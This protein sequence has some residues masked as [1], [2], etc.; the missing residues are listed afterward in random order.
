MK[1]LLLLFIVTFFGNVIVAQYR[2]Y[3][4]PRNEI[5]QTIVRT[6]DQGYLI[7]SLQFC[8][9]PEEWV[10]EGCPLGIRL[11]K[12]NETGDSLWSA[13]IS[14]LNVQGLLHLFE[15]RDGTF[16]LFTSQDGTFTCQGWQIGPDFGLFQLLTYHISAT[17]EVLSQYAFPEDCHLPL[18]TVTRLSDTTYVALATYLEPFAS[19]TVEGRIY[20]LDQK[21]AV[22]ETADVPGQSFFKADVVTDSLN[23]ILVFFIDP[24]SNGVLQIYDHNLVLLEEKTSGEFSTPCMTAED[25]RGS[26]LMQANGNLFFMCDN[27]FGKTDN[28]EVFSF[29]TDL[30]ILGHKLYTIPLSAFITE[31]EDASIVILSEMRNEED[32]SNITLTYLNE[33]G[34]SIET[35]S[36]RIPGNQNPTQLLAFDDERLA[37]VGSHNCCNLN[38][39]IGPGKTFLYLQEGFTSVWP[40]SDVHD[41]MVY[42]NPA[43]DEVYVNTFEADVIARIK[44]FSST[45]IFVRE[46]VVNNSGISVKDL[47]PGLYYL[48][49]ISDKKVVSRGRFVKTQ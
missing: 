24:D 30:A 18:G 17:G 47:E 9:T 27:P 10:I 14:N 11:L 31:D 43:N 15:N 19:D 36:F 34:D 49:G 41:L 23:R 3:D 44:L 28:V 25:T 46:N 45:G 1:T 6:A 35:I 42:P 12:T 8:Y 21:G 40:V 26:M 7:A 37:I 33:V 20:L 29:T 48:V 2:V 4:S 22:L 5:N 39:D 32:S 13:V 16:T 38:A